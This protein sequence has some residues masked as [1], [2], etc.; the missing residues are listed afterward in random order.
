MVIILDTMS[1]TEFSCVKIKPIFTAR[2]VLKQTHRVKMKGDNL[3]SCCQF[4]N[5]LLLSS[6]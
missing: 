2:N 3:R 4:W 6:K 5:D 1:R